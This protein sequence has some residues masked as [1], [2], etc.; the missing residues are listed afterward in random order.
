LGT[1]VFL[2][3]L[4]WSLVQS[5]RSAGNRRLIFWGG[6]WWLLF[7]A[8]VLFFPEHRDPWN[9]VVAAGGLAFILAI[10]LTNKG[11]SA[12][13]GAG[14]YLG[15]F[16]VGLVYYHSRHWVMT[17]AALVRETQPLV[18]DQCA[19]EQ[20]IF[21]QEFRVLNQELHYAWY[22]DSGPKVFCDNPKLTVHYPDG[23]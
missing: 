23:Q 8:P 4:A 22:Y 6:F 21:P 17:R 19:H 2:S 12:I 18:A 11:I 1:L 15:L 14:A 13:L 20:V 3:V 5:W 7:L 16:L 10:T 9:L